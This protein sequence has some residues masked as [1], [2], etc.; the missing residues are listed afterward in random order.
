MAEIILLPI[1]NSIAAGILT[2]ILNRFLIRGDCCTPQTTV[3]QE[4]ED[5]HELAEIV[6]V[7]SCSVITQSSG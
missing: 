2:S 6:S 1:L 4:H 7:S 3:N 5:D